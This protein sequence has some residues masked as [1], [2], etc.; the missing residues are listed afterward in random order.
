VE[1]LWEKIRLQKYG[2]NVE[3]NSVAIIWKK[4]G[5]E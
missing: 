1:A 5:K 4:C 3:K 2:K